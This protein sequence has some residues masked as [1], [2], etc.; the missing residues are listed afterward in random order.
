MS[1][2]SSGPAPWRPAE[3]VFFPYDFMDEIFEALVFFFFFDL[4]FQNK[5]VLSQFF[6]NI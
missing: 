2:Q 1:P 4:L 3:G 5:N 6:V